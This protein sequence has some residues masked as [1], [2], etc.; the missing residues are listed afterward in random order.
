MTIETVSSNE[1]STL[2]KVEDNEKAAEVKI[3]VFFMNKGNHLNVF[4]AK[5]ISNKLRVLS[6]VITP[7]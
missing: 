7:F 5:N 2:K 1:K 6:I 3:S 4:C